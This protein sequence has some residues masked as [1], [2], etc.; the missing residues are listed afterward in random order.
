MNN[1]FLKMSLIQKIRIEKK[2]QYVTRYHTSGITHT[3]SFSYRMGRTH[4]FKD[5]A[6]NSYNCSFGCR[7]IQIVVVWNT[8]NNAG[9]IKKKKIASVQPK[10]P[11]HSE[12][13]RGTV[14]AVHLRNGS[15]WNIHLNYWHKKSKLLYPCLE[16]SIPMY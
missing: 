4:I 14:C 7:V 11:N 6:K 9:R 10:M 13:F 12:Q 5:Q 16:P 1:N 3:K 8:A 2:E 15:L